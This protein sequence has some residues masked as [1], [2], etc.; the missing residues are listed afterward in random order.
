VCEFLVAVVV[1]VFLVLCTTHC[2]SVEEVLG[3]RLGHKR[4]H[5]PIRVVLGG[6]TRLSRPPAIRFERVIHIRSKFSREPER[7]CSRNWGYDI[8]G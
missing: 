3:G 8:I 1:P 4:L 5:A 6:A 7:K 2:E